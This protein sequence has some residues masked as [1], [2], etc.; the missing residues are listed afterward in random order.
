MGNRFTPYFLFILAVCTPTVTF[1]QSVLQRLINETKDGDTLYIEKNDYVSDNS[2]TLTGR[3][4]LTLFFEEGSTVTCTSKFQDIFVLQ[5]CSDIQFYNGTYRHIVP[6]D[7]DCYGSAFYVFESDNIHITNVDIVNN[8]VQ[9]IF[10]QNVFELELTNCLIRNNTASA[11]LFQGS[12]KNFRIKGM[13]Y[14]KNG[15]MGDNVFAYSNSKTPIDP[16]ESIEIKDFG[17]RDSLRLDSIKNQVKTLFES[18]RKPMINPEQSSME[19]DSIHSKPLDKVLA[20]STLFPIWLESSTE[21]NQTTVGFKLPA[22]VGQYLCEASG[23][24]RFDTKDAVEFFKYDEPYFTNI[25]PKAFLMSV[26]KEVVYLNESTPTNIHWSCDPTL[27]SMVNELRN[28]GDLQIAKAQETLIYRLLQ[29]WESYQTA[30]LEYDKLHFSLVGK[31]RF[32][33]SEYDASNQ[34][35]DVHLLLDD[36][37]VATLRVPMKTTQVQQLFFN[38]D[39]FTVYFSLK[40]QPGYKQVQFNKGNKNE[41]CCTFPNPILLEKPVFE[42]Y[43]QLGN[44][45]RFTSNSMPS[46]LWPEGL[47]RLNWKQTYPT[48]E[49]KAYQYT[50]P[51]TM[52]SLK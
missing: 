19:Y 21:S 36:F 49:N 48:Q 12:Y 32:I 22:N 35:L 15:P 46:Q 8:G 5:K 24:A 33:R 39:D 17:E 1:S 14:E 50:I 44:R 51:G 9:G 40:V 38:R 23:L 2:I 30:G 27:E 31:G 47:I 45:F 13:K 20:E 11:Y 7:A 43:N 3:K 37:Y 6:V 34:C 42:C 25:S 52:N 26:K 28:K 41:T 10:T 16:T 29:V 18:L 4:Q